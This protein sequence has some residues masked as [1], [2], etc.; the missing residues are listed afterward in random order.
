MQGSL[1]FGA[2]ELVDGDGYFRVLL[3]TDDETDLKRR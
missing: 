3:L 1:G 2:A